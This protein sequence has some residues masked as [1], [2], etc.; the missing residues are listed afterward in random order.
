MREPVGSAG[1]PVYIPACPSR[2][3]L[4]SADVGGGAGGA[5][6]GAVGL[7]YKALPGG[8]VRGHRPVYPPLPPS[9]APTRRS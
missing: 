4:V 8:I 2:L 3:R 9:P 7:H 1:Q 5:G 6:G